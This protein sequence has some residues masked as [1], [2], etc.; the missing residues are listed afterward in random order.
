MADT[1]K[2]KPSSEQALEKARELWAAITQHMMAP[3]A[4]NGNCWNTYGVEMCQTALDE[5]KAIKSEE[6]LDYCARFHDYMWAAVISGMIWD[7]D[8]R[9]ASMRLTSRM[10]AK[11][12]E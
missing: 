3:D 4:P 8:F 6:I 10:E 1:I 7:M 5:A 2:S 9:D 12:G 11:N